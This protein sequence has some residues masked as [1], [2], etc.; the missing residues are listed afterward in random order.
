MATDCVKLSLCGVL[1]A[2]GSVATGWTADSFAGS[3]FFW[4]SHSANE[5]SCG[6]SKQVN[7]PF[8][9]NLR[10]KCN[11]M[12]ILTT[13]YSFLV[14]N[15]SF[16][17][18]VKIIQFD[19]LPGDIRDA[20][21]SIPELLVL[22][23]NTLVQSPGN[24]QDKN[25]KSFNP[26]TA[27][28]SAKRFF[29]SLLCERNRTKQRTLLGSMKTSGQL[30]IYKKKSPTTVHKQITDLDDLRTDFDRAAA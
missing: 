15:A 3:K 7:N 13:V 22:L 4:A 18:V 5:K 2:M 9:L 12:W 20:K 27:L 8:D 11:K 1:T 10:T 14:Y 28:V 25:L 6:S 29:Y 21:V 23:F 24:L 19:F 17:K 26:T 30:I 16:S